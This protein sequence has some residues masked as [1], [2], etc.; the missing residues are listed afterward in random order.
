[1]Y[2][3]TR[4]SPQWDVG[5][6]GLTWLLVARV[7]KSRLN[8]MEIGGIRKRRFRAIWKDKPFLKGSVGSSSG[9]AALSSS[10]TPEGTMQDVFAQLSR[11][12]VRPEPPAGVSKPTGNELSARVVRRAEQLR[13]EWS[14]TTLTL[15]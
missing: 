15:F 11:Y 7:G 5:V 6:T 12:G 4:V 13:M 14:G 2:L 10:A 1:V 9:F 3:A 8:A